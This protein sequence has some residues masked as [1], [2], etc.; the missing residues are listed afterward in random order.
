MK[1]MYLFLHNSVMKPKIFYQLYIIHFFLIMILLFPTLSILILLK[2]TKE[3]IWYSYL[4][5]V[6]GVITD[7]TSSCIVALDKCTLYIY[8]NLREVNF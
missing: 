4:D 7:E 3:D 2:S 5:S 1:Y 6:F 8:K